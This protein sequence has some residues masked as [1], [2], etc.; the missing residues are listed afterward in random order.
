MTDSFGA[1]AQQ[2]AGYSDPMRARYLPTYDAFDVVH[3]SVAP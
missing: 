2:L 3:A 1:L